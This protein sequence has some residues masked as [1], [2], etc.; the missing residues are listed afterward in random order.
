MKLK[1]LILAAIAATLGS[2]SATVTLQ[3]NAGGFLG[4]T[5]QTTG[6]TWGVV[7]DNGGDGFDSYRS[8]F[9]LTNGAIMG[10]SDD[11]FLWLSA[12]TT[13]A[14]GGGGFITTV[15]GV[16]D[17]QGNAFGIVWFDSTLQSGEAAGS[18]N[19]YGFYTQASFVMPAPGSTT[20]FT[21]TVTNSPTNANLP[22]VPEPSVAILGALGA[23]GLIRRRR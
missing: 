14:P 4:E 3:F 10:G 13:L 23:L 5:G 1:A 2:A 19:T 12:G 8:G 15:S 7:V 17:S 11:D 6:I 18:A 20:A 16:A 21:G 22:L 9:S